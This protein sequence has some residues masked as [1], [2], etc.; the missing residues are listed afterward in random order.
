[1]I[2]IL[3]TGFVLAGVVCTPAPIYHVQAARPV[4]PDIR[5]D[6]RLGALR[7][8]FAKADCPAVRYA[9]VF[10]EAADYYR[11]DWRL[12]PSISFVEST[13]GKFAHNNN[14]FGWD[15]GK[16]SFSSPAQAIHSV[17]Y[18][19]SHSGGYKSKSVE[20]VLARYNPNADYV[21]KVKSVM[22]RI[23]PEQ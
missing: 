11:L 2:K 21:A 5:P 16:A 22:R 9:E 23:A 7:S 13:G 3:S 8:F 10:L 18:S 4:P 12:L 14:F 6:A 17:G 15:S 1:M 19:L 20:T